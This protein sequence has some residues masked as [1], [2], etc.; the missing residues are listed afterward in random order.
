M[1]LLIW[2]K[3][4]W[5]DC[6]VGAIRNIN[7]LINGILL[8]DDNWVREQSGRAWSFEYYYHKNNGSLSVSQGLYFLVVP[9]FA[10]KN[11]T[12]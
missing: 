11:W 10:F 12:N 9:D 2:I 4:Q 3:D 1:G 8:F 5:E 7:Q 6:E